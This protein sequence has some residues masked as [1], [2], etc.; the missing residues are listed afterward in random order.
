MEG[1][2]VTLQDL[3]LYDFGMGV[4]DEG[5]A[6]GHLKATGLRPGFSDLLRN[7]GIELA[8]ELFSPERFARQPL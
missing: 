3:F 2:I 4:D 6:L 1:D 7:Q 5:R 8:P